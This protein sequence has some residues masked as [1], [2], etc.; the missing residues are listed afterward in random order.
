MQ[1]SQQHLKSIKIEK[2]K[3]LENVSCSFEPNAITAI[4]GINGCGKST[5]LHALACCF[6]PQENGE[7]HR[8]SDFF[9]PNN[10][11]AWE[12]SSFSIEYT[13]R[14]G[15]N[16]KVNNK[17]YKKNSD[18]WTRYVNRPQRDVFYIGIDSCVPDIEK[19]KSKSKITIQ[20]EN[21]N[22]ILQT[23][24]EKISYIL[25]GEYQN[26]FNG[27]RN[28]KTYRI[29][30][31]NNIEY[32]SIAMG[33]GE[34]RLLTILER[35]FSAPRY[36]LI[37]IDELDL[38]LHT[39]ALNRLIDIL[40]DK[41]KEKHL[42]IV[43]TTHRENITIREDINIRHIHGTGNKTFCFE[44]INN[45]CMDIITGVSEKKIKIFVEDLFSKSI[46][47]SIAIGLKIQRYCEV[48]TFGDI[49]NGFT[50]ASAK[51]VENKDI[52]N[53]LVV[54]DGD[55]YTTQ[56]EKESQLN[57]RFS[58]NT[59]YEDEVRKLALT[60][61]T[62]YASK[63]KESP[64]RF[65]INLLKQKGQDGELLD[66]VNELGKLMDNH[67]YIESIAS[68]LGIDKSLTIDKLINEIKNLQE[69]NEY[70]KPIKEWMMKRKEL[71][72]LDSPN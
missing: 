60:L 69:W 36:S 33:A 39:Q 34:Q 42:Q 18:R 47:N 49:C 22:H 31:R 56:E 43:F 14:D 26:C 68:K 59:K 16:E 66:I 6:Q 44:G 30:K 54:L 5:I 23:I 4:L 7:N 51:A 57:S 58:G 21:E 64:E 63:E 46:I 50:I 71:L 9:L 3:Q 62:E 61:I 13:Y 35:I 15:Q 53:I 10:Y 27:L 17:T 1:T 40:N 32:P 11:N 45:A 19:E 20:K 65:V 70:I 28:K 41:A 8:F 72:V 29:I 38:T 2:L 48:Q 67:K 24:I 25:G 37:L 52:D 12:G 55:K